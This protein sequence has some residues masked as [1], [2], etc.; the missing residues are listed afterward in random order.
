MRVHD[1]GGNGIRARLPLSQS[2][3]AVFKEPWHARALAVTLA[4]GAL[5]EWNLDSSRHAR[6]LLLPSDYLEMSYYERWLAALAN[7]LVEHNL[8][9]EDELAEPD[10][11]GQR[12]DLDSRCLQSANVDKLL[13]SG[14]PTLRRCDSPFRFEIGDIVETRNPAENAFRSGGHTRLPAYAQGRKGRIET[15]HG[16]HVLPDANAHFL[17]ERPEPLYSVRFSADELWGPRAEAAEDEVM[18]DLWESYLSS[19]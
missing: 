1:M 4:A 10:G 14:G 13:S 2:E 15:V 5:G 9:T 8:V 18:I 7:L 19:A 17:G 16:A 11:C 12:E 3:C 6:E